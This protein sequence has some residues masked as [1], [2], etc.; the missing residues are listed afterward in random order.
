[1]AE[2]VTGKLTSHAIIFTISL[3]VHETVRIPLF[4]RSRILYEQSVIQLANRLVLRS[5]WTRGVGV[6]LAILGSCL[7]RYSRQSNQKPLNVLIP[8]KFADWLILSL[9]IFWSLADLCSEPLLKASQHELG[10]PSEFIVNLVF[11]RFLLGNV[12]PMKR[13]RGSMNIYE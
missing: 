3:R 7:D 11:S 6:F 12:D 2:L 8:S 13:S 9:I 10:I 1:M 5:F 4:W